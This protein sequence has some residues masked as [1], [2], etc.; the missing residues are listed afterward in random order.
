M[1]I[2]IDPGHNATGGDRGASGFGLLEEDASFGI[3]ARLAELLRAAGHEV[4]LSRNSASESVGDGTVNSSLSARC[5]MANEWGAELFCSIHC[6][7]ANGAAHGTETLVYSGAGAAAEV[8]QRVQAA[9]VSRLG[10][11]DRGVKERPGLYVLKHTEMPAILVETAFIDNEAD[12]WLLKSRP[13]DFAAAIAEGI[14]G[15]KIEET[16]G[17]NVAQTVIKLDNIYMQRMLP[18]EFEIMQA[19][20][21]KREIGLPNYFNLGFF[22]VEAGGKTIPVGNLAVEGEIVAQAADN[23]DWINLAGHELTTLYTTKNG[24]AGMAKTS[25]LDGLE[26]L[27]FAVSGIPILRGGKSVS[28]DEIKSEGYDGSE[29][30]DT[31]HGFLGIRGGEILYVAMECGFEMMKYYLDYLGI[32]DAVKLDGG[33]SFILKNGREIAGTSENR[34]IHNVG[35]WKG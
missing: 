8:A 14:T 27:R 26:G 22:A 28:L 12:C 31:W 5:R 15:G 33:G 7:A 23:A 34:R 30:Y 3:G 35:V 16:E 11:A 20:C 4:K 18:A 19:D 32:S 21:A 6:N 25:R 9:I 17:N 1:K 13:D 29:L 10:T 2:F 24:G